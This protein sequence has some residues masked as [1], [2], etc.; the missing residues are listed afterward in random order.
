MFSMRTI[1]LF[2]LSAATI[3][4]STRGGGKEKEKDASWKRFSSTKKTATFFSNKSPSFHPFPIRRTSITCSMS[5]EMMSFSNVLALCPPR[6]PS[7][8]AKSVVVVFLSVMGPSACIPMMGR[9]FWSKKL[10]DPVS[11]WVC[12]KHFWRVS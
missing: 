3:H 10:K 7:S 11:L 8:R 2:F 1:H 5:W 6:K 12:Q 9:P 4:V